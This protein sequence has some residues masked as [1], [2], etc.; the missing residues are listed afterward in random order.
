MGMAGTVGKRRMQDARDARL[1]LQPARHLQCAIAV[2]P[3]PDA[4][5][6]QPARRQPGV[7]GT[8][9]LA[10]EIGGLANL[11]EPVGVC[12]DATHHDIAMADDIFGAG[13]DGDVDAMSHGREIERRRPGIVHQR[14]DAMRPRPGGD[15]RHILHLESEASGAFQKDGADRPGGKKRVE[16]RRLRIIIDGFDAVLAEHLGA[17]GPGRI[18]GAVDHEQPI[19][20]FQ[21]SHQRAGDRRHA[22]RE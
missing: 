22:R 1:I 11:A 18:V 19:A 17:E 12:G 13:E 9:H 7:V 16:V 20:R 5:R 15:G 3:Q 4:Q 14:D 8:D 10:E 6:A 21:H 2:L